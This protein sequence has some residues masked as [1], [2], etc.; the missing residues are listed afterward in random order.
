MNNQQIL[1]IIS[2]LNKKAKNSTRNCLF[3]GCDSTAIDSH[4]LQRK[5]II[6]GISEN[7]H[8]IEFAIDPFRDNSFYFKST[9]WKDVFTFPGFCMTHDDGIFKEVETGDIKYTDYRTQLLFSYRATMIE[10]RKKEIVVDWYDR[11][12]N[13]STLRQNLNHP[14]FFNI[15]QQRKQ[16][17]LGINDEKHYEE[18]F[19]LNIQDQTK[20]DFEFITFELPRIELCSSAVFTYETTEEINYIYQYESHKSTE[21]LT[22]I[23]FNMLPNKNET[24]VI[25]GCL[26]EKKEKCWNFITS[27]ND[28]NHSIALKK[29]SDLLLC[30]VENWI[31]SKSFY[32]QN[33]KKREKEII[34]IAH[35]STQHPNERREL[36]LNIFENIGI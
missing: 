4:L 28:K 12:L 16:E 35:E 18:H 36:D 5:G 1:K 23:Y 32:N 3:K 27:F 24:I 11:L 25:L 7:N 31:C 33:I 30:Q 13:N 20:K 29:I 15:H 10:N 6:S 21:P 8:V 9:G 34:R 26:K 19:L 2:D 14:F 22:E 17:L